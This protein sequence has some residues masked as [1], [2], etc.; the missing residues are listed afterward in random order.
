MDFHTQTGDTVAPIT[1]LGEEIAVAEQE[2][3]ERIIHPSKSAETFLK[4][5]WV[6]AAAALVAS[7]TTYSLVRSKR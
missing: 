2:K 6:L 5:P 1:T 4:N 7:L 3:L